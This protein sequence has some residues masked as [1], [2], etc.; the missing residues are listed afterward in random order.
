[1][2]LD[3]RDAALG[4]P[5]FHQFQAAADAGQDVVEVMCQAAGELAHG[6][7][8][9]RLAQGFL[10]FQQGSG[11]FLHALFQRVVEG[12][13]RSQCA[14]AFGFDG[15]PPFDV[16]QHTGEGAGMAVRGQ[17]H[18]AIGFQPVVAAVAAARAVL[19]SIG[20]TTRQGFADAGGKQITVVRMH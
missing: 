8:L 12:A 18:A 17:L 14:I 5:H 13:Q 2:A 10:G 16:D 7:H 4:Q 1:M 15:A 9:L 6:F 11:A 3:V 20:T 19:V